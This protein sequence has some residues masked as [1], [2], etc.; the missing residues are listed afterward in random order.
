MSS[1]PFSGPDETPAERNL[2]VRYY[3]DL[4]WRGRTL[5]GAAALVGALLGLF[6]AFLRTPEYRAAAMLQIDP[7]TPTFMSV[8]DALVGAGAYWQN[9]DFYN[10]QFKVLRSKGLGEKVV[11]HLK[12]DGRPPFQ[13]NPDA[14][15]LFM[16]HVGVEPYPESRLVTLTVTH[17]DPKEA[18]L[19]VNALS[20]VYIESSL[21]S[22]VETAKRA[23]EWLQER[24]SA[25]QA[26]MREAQEKL[27]KSLEGQ[28]LF[29]PEGSVSA[30]STS[31]AKLNDDYLEARTRR[32]TIEAVV[33]QARDMR[34]R[35]ETLESIPQVASDSV[36]VGLNS[37]IASLTVDLSRLLEKFKPAHPEVQKV[38]AQLVEV[39]KARAARGE[40][41]LGG[42]QAEYAQLLKREAELRAAI[43]AQKSLAASQSR[44]VGELDALKKEA[45]SSKSLYEVLLQKLNESDIAASIKSNNVSVVE[46]ASVPRMPVRPDKRKIALIGLVLGLALGV[47][48][49]LGRDYLDNTMRDPEEVERYLHLDLLAAVPSYETDNAHLVTEAYQN[50]RTALLFAR[51]SEEGQVVLIT[52]SA[53][54]EGKTTTLV[55]MAKLLAGAG[56]KTV[57]LD[58]DLRRAQLHHRLGQTREPGLTDHFTRHVPLLDL[59]KPAEVANLFVL[60]AGPLPPNPPALLARK[61]VQ[62]LFAELKTRFDWILVDSPPL[63]SVTDALLLARHADCV[64]M[65]VQ[66]NKV[67]KKVVKRS[68]NALRKATPN[69]LGVVLNQVD[70]QQK[71]YYYYY[72]Q[73]DGGGARKGEPKAGPEDTPPPPAP[74]APGSRPH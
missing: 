53:P 69:V 61:A 37:Q 54:Q 46:R 66:H 68:V 1:P 20:D 2:D 10:T 22:R 23:Y 41:I 70:V 29:V 11:K 43:D 44:K 25:T 58:C 56:E 52:G 45:E 33:Q 35:G 8:T 42:L 57:V 74:D 71:G 24:L 47:G 39:R 67:D 60:T 31:I 18:T 55:N 40:A 26:D 38:E 4:L 14:G 9:T 21:E 30:V 59:L 34:A 63:A 27:Y 3:A 62:D 16:A 6:V 48:L 19:W 17:P 72:Y 64:V 50:L 7:P 12:L 65:V 32:I 13:D 5:V 28:D 15:V 73:H 51:K 36:V 49:V